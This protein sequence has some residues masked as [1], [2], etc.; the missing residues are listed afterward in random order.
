MP[1]TSACFQVTPEFHAQTISRPRAQ[2]N[3]GPAFALRL[4]LGTPTFATMVH[5]DLGS[6][7]SPPTQV[8]AQFLGNATVRGR[9]EA[10]KGLR[11]TTN[12]TQPAKD[13]ARLPGRPRAEVQSSRSTRSGH[14]S[15]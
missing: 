1:G 13:L 14:V 10:L 9:P 15:C 6:H 4:R 3:G 5:P 11:V 8:T 12:G 2:I 7:A